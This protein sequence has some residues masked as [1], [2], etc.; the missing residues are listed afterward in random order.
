MKDVAQK[1]EILLRKKFFISPSSQIYG[2]VSGLYDYGPYGT[3]LKN[4]I[5]SFWRKFFVEEENALEI[6]ACILTPFEV[7]KA[8]GHVD[9]F[10]D[11]LVFDKKTGECFRAD[12]LLAQELSKLEKTPEI[13]KVLDDVETLK[14]QQVDEIL[15]KFGIKSLAG[16]E[17][18]NCTRFNL[19]FQTNIGPKTQN[20]SFLR[21]ETAQ[22]QFVNFKK[23]Y[24]LN[25]EKMPFASASVG[26]VFRN[27]ISPRQGV[28]RVREFEQA[29][30]EYY[31]YPDQKNCSKF[32]NVENLQ[33]TLF[34]QENQNKPQ[35]ENKI[36]LKDAV[37]KKIIDNETLGYFIGR[38]YLFLTQIGIKEDKLRFRQHKKDEMAHYACDCWD[39]EILTSYGYIEC[40]GI[41]DRACYDLSMHQKHSKTNLMAKK[42]LDE[43]IDT[44]CWTFYPDKKVLGKILRT[45]LPKFL[46]V[47]EKYS[48]EDIEKLILDQKLCDLNLTHE[49]TEKTLEIDIP[50]NNGKVKVELRKEKKKT[51]TQEIFPNVIEPSFGIGRILYACL[52]HS[53][54]TRKDDDQRNI[55]SIQPKIAPLK[56]VVTLLRNSPEF[57]IIVDNLE[58]DFKRN[59]LNFFMCERNVSIGKKYA[60]Y[61]EIGVPFFVTIDLDTL[62]DS[63]CTIRERDSMEQIRIKLATIAETI[64]KL[65]IGEIKWND[66]EI[67]KFK[68]N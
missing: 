42:K 29:E 52:E 45:N 48:Q 68:I 44:I 57:K 5:I 36:T 1:L 14:P 15:E 43:P 18:G 25:N 50:Y 62:N 16:N 9:K 32:K 7:L 56:C 67:A 30:I 63:M 6:D 3:M 19:I 20:I 10:T 35:T 60:S 13:E 2:G 28:L 27:E 49:I 4:N 26:K 21:P 37:S 8:S 33:L 12:H 22:S 58:K 23:L 59:S 64:R 17:I 54:W 65:I 31:V 39:A 11:L 47:L 51:Y 61:D 24:E 41:A 66:H 55:L 34:Y 38:T 46:E 40:V 53:F